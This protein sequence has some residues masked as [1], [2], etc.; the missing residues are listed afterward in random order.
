MVVTL[1]D[2]PTVENLMDTLMAVTDTLT[3]QLE[4]TLTVE[5]M[6]THMTTVTLMIMDTDIPT[7][8]DMVI[9][10]DRMVILMIYSERTRVVT[11]RLCRVHFFIF[12]PTLWGQ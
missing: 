11:W 4:S 8:A 6:D 1:M 2:T 7:I 3:K 10:T 9:H 12:S 5:I